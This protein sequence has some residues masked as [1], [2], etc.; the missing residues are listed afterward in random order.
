MFQKSGNLLAILV[1]EELKWQE[2]N[3]ALPKTL[4]KL[5]ALLK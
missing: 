3:N 5:T 4:S 2:Q 1:D